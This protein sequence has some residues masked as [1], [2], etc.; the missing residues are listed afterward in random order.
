MGLKQDNV[1]EW[2]DMSTR[3]CCFCELAQYKS[4]AYPRSARFTGQIQ[5]LHPNKASCHNMAE[6]MLNMTINTILNTPP[7]FNQIVISGIG[8]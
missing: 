6:K 2:S 4:Y 1:S 5:A 3:D 8:L 7:L